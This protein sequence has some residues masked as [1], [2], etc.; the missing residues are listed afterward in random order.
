MKKLTLTLTLLLGCFL[1]LAQSS[2]AVYWDASYSMKDRN[3]DRELKFLDNYF[4][5]HTDINVKLIM[6]SNEIILEDNIKVENSDWSALRRELQKTIYDGA[7]T[8]DYLFKDQVDEYLLFTDGVENLSKLDPP[9]TKPIHIVSSIDDTNTTDLKLV[10]D[11]SSGRF[12]YLPKDFEP[13]VKEKKELMVSGRNDGFI[14][15]TIEGAEGRL[16]NVSVVNQTNGN[17]VASTTEGTY[18][19]EASEGD[20]LIY[21]YLG[22][23]TVSLRVSKADIINIT[24]SD[25]NQNLEEVVLTAQAEKEEF[26]MVNTGNTKT[27]ERSLGYSV[28]SIDSDD[29]SP[30]DTDVQQAVKGQF[31]NFLLPNDTAIDDVDLSQFLGRGRNM[32]ILLNQYGLVVVDGVPQEQSTSEFGGFRSRTVSTMNPDIIE[33][34]TYLKGLAATNKYGTLGRNGVLL[35]TTKM[36]MANPGRNTNENTEPLGTTATY[37]G[38]AEELSDLANEPYIE[39]LKPA[40]SVNEAFIIYLE[41]REEF[42]D[43]PFFFIDVHDYFKGWN[44]PLI[45]ERI[46]S[47]VFEIAY[48]DVKV[49]KVVAFKQLENGK[50]R[51]ALATIERIVQIEPKQSQSYR[52]L[53]LGYSMAGEYQK[54]LELYKRIDKNLNVG[55]T[56]FTGLRRTIQNEM[57]NLIAQ[58]GQ[59]LNLLGVDD[60]Y[61]RPVKYRSRIVFEWNDLDV[62]FDLNIVNPQ[63]RFFTWSHTQAE[64]SQRI[65]QQHQEGYGLEEFYLTSGDLGEW[66]FNMKYYGKTSNDKAPA[67]IKISTY[68]NFGS[69][70]QTVDIKV[71]RMDKQDIEQ[72]VAKLLV[73]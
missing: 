7:S 57:K 17:G 63:N 41:Q 20:I 4:K 36:A 14:L 58:H 38:N 6:F 62:E 44:N 55:S 40:K 2:V 15:G 18:N 49:L 8:Y 10:S 3:L 28:E 39:A 68:K 32:S 31:A 47:N 72:T 29:I 73:N 61:K 34:I 54:A 69:P 43:S 27:D 67:F 64:N 53:A 48:D 11:K 70:N 59:Q 9:T 24:M 52:D 26:E 25:I 13:K 45:S 51:D 30:L 22:K 21:S 60:K 71:V 12:V 50:Y 33:S 66:K 35:I 65:L 56:D 19:I 23:K 37:R 5:K 42:G 46:L 1:G 16:V